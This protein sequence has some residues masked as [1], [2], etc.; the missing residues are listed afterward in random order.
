MVP[1]YTGGVAG[2]NYLLYESTGEG[3]DTFL[4]GN[5]PLVNVSAT[6]VLSGPHQITGTLDIPY[7]DLVNP[8]GSPLLRRWKTTL[9]LEDPNEKIWVGGILADY[10]ITDSKLN[11]D[12]TGFTTQIKEQP[13]DADV[14]AVQVDP[15][16]VTRDIWMHH[17]GEAGGNLGL[18][19]DDTKSPVRIGVIEPDTIE[20]REDGSQSVTKGNDQSFK[21]NWW[22]TDDSGGVIDTLAKDTPFDY[23]EEHYWV[24]SQVHHRL[25]LGYPG[26]GEVKGHLRFV[27][28]ENVFKVPTEDYTGDHVITE[29]WVFGAGEG[30]TMIR[31]I[32]KVHPANSVRRVRKIHDKKITS[33]AH[34]QARAREILEGY[35][36]TTPGAGITEL[37]VR[38]HTNAP[39]GSYDV[40]DVVVYSGDH[41]WGDVVIWMKIVK[42]TVTPDA[43]D[44][45]VLT[46]VR[47]D[48]LG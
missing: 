8:D 14:A 36:P 13:F 3:Y 12:I 22:S 10:T 11:L 21:L 37:L 38:N 44:D 25:R 23:L 1:A 41:E 19:L 15:L 6:K 42:M 34:A 43:G 2:W 9:Y 40:G 7:R 48:N 17:Q 18:V 5:V 39:L 16:D 35:Q 31:G 46:V 30:R 47:A 27:L 28:G 45:V 4:K 20:T 29:V 33:T 32:A 26:L 24:G